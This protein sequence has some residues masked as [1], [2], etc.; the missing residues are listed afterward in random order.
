LIRRGRRW[1]LAAVL[2][3]IALL[4]GVRDAGAAT[5]TADPAAVYAAAI[6]F[7]TPRLLTEETP[8]RLVRW[9]LQGLTTID[10][11][12]Q[13]EENAG[14]VGLRTDSGILGGQARP[15]DEDAAGWGAVAA[16]LTTVAADISR[17]VR[18]AGADD[19]MDAFFDELFSHFDPYS[20][21]VPPNEAGEDRAKR[22]GRL[23]LAT[24]Q[25]RRLGGALVLRV[26]MF[27]EGI[28][29]RLGAALRAAS[30]ARRRPSGLVLDLRGN[31][32]GLVR[33]AVSVAGLLL[34]AGVV[35]TTSGRDPAAAHVWRT[36]DTPVVQ[37]LP[38][39]VLVDGQTASAAE[40]LSAAL[41]DRGR[42]V[43]VGSATFGKGLVQTIAQLPN[44]GELFVTWARILAPDGWPLQDL[45]VMPQVCTSLGPNV[46]DDTLAALGHGHL[47]QATIAALTA[48]RAARPSLSPDRLN[49]IR[50]ACPAAEGRADD[51]RAARTLLANPAA[52]SAAL[53]PHDQGVSAR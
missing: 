36:D 3:A 35:A 18:A 40:I 7:M 12:L 48:S 2:F 43:V 10:P 38:I 32:G 51:L 23:H 13:I 24:L 6:G 9:G 26:T 53:L 28:T 41:A 15:A 46:V 37:D 1:A 11:S 49:A 39:I 31:R 25:T 20:R 4:L 47:P 50:S 33:E 45:G 34:P 21:Y 16:N 29:T 42:A 8:S 44:G 22:A 19:V 27:D 30:A 14:L 5:Q 17:K 52:Y